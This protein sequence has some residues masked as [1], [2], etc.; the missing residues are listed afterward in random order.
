ME[1]ITWRPATTLKI[2]GKKLD[3]IY[4]I[5]G[6]ERKI[7]RLA[8]TRFR[9]HSAFMNFHSGEWIQKVADSYA[10]FIGYVWTSEK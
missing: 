10:G 1:A 2:H 6:S 7:S 3:S 8:S 5:V 9:I 4:V